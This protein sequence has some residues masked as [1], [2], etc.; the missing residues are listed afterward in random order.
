MTME[1]ARDRDLRLRAAGLRYHARLRLPAR[2][3]IRCLAGKLRTPRG[4]SRGID[5]GSRRLGGEFGH[6]AGRNPS[7]RSPLAERHPGFARR[8]QGGARTARPIK[9]D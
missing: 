3:P 5:V 6:S 8:W 9:P 4:P 7:R 2:G 1:T